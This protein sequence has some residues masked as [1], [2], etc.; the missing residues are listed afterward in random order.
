[1]TKRKRSNPSKKVKKE[2]TS[3][4]FDPRAVLSKYKIQPIS[5]Y[6]AN[7]MQDIVKLSNK[8]S[9]TVKQESDRQ[10][11]LQKMEINVKKMKEGI[12]KPPLMEKISENISVP[13]YDIDNIMKE[14]EHDIKI[15]RKSL[16]IIEGQTS[17]WYD[18]YRDA[19]VRLKQMLE[20]FIGED[21][22]AKNVTGTR[23]GLSAKSQE[24]EEEIFTTEFEKKVEDLTLDDKK[25]I[26]NAMKV[27]NAS[28]TR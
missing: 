2:T 20:A 28:Q 3:P 6:H 19:I 25:K 4:I 1:M 23:Q 22:E 14:Y 8:F 21:I 13:R 18:E 5:Q 10:M 9:Q 11:V 16:V 7:M 27:N 26:K 12:I 15:I 17:H 24:L